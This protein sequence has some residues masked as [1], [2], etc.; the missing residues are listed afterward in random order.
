MVWPLFTTLKVNAILFARSSGSRPYSDVNGCPRESANE[1]TKRGTDK[2]AVRSTADDVHYSLISF[3][4]SPVCGT[5]RRVN[6]P[7]LEW[8]ENNEIKENFDS[9]E[10]TL[11]GWNNVSESK[12]YFF[13]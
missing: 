4:F 6:V 8:F 13:P 1:H 12:H 7:K 11:C 2:N 10:R 5:T 9:K 3:D